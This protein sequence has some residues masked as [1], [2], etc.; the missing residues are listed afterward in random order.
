MKKV[1]SEEKEQNKFIQIIKKK[2]L[3][4]GT[5]TIILFAIIIAIFIALNVFLQSLDLTPIDLSQEQLYTLTESSK[6][7]IKTIEKDVNL[8]F[9]GFA[10]EDPTVD[11]AKQYKNVNAKIKVEVVTAESRPDLVTKYGIE[12]GSTGIIVECGEKSKVLTTNDLYTYDMTTYETINIAEERLTSSIMTVVSNK[13]PKIYF[14]EGYS[15][16]YIL[17]YNMKYLGIYL[18]NEVN[19]VETINVLS[20]GKI[21]DDC[22]TL[23][24]C[25]PSKDFDDIVTNEIINYIN[26]GRNI[27]WLN[28]AVTENENLP[29]VNKILGLYGV[30]PFEVGIILETDTKKMLSQTPYIIFPD[31]E[32]SEI[33]KN[34]Y[35]TTGVLF[36]NPTKINF[37][38]DESLENLKVVKN[39]LLKASEKSFFRTNFNIQTTYQTDL[40]ENGEFVVGAELVK[41][42][43]SSDEENGVSEIKSKMVIF[44]ENNFITDYP[45]GNSGTPVLVLEHNK[46]LM[47]NSMAYL[48][49]RQ[50]DITARKSTGT[51]AYTATEEQ[52]NIIKIVIFAVPILIIIA[53]IVVWIV[54]RRKK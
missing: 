8:Y 10:E 12:S 38:D 43:Q 24:I 39:D 36:I 42:I 52:N 45:I 54:R 46:D 11:L 14:L 31:I 30:K 20:N 41:T 33:T 19:E 6:D 22:D 53:G 44:G 7:K 9:V 23:I 28:A 26:S 2:W 47:L 29:N 32:Y 3:I 50:E 16:S 17:S 21:P 48:V 5:T 37:V 1:N 15:D 25:S 40:D 34:I 27:L 4:K 51:V 18:Q 35:N 13:I 49:D